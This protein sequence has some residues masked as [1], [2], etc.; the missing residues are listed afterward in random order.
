MRVVITGA[1]GG[2]GRA[3]VRGFSNA[4]FPVRGLVRTPTACRDLEQVCGDIRDPSAA[5]RLP[6]GAD[7]IIHVAGVAHRSICG[8]PELAQLFHD[9]N[10]TGTENVCRA[11]VDAGTRAIMLISSSAVYGRSLRAG[12]VAETAPCLPDSAYGASKVGAEQA[13][14][15][16]CRG[17]STRLRVL[18][19]ATVYGPGTR[20]NITRLVKMAGR[21]VVV[22]VAPGTARKSLI[23]IDDLVR[24]CLVLAAM[25]PRTETL[26][27]AGCRGYAVREI[28]HAIRRCS[29]R[30]VR[31]IWLPRPLVKLIARGNEY[32]ARSR[33]FPCVIDR[34][35]I[36]A[37]TEDAVIDASRLH[38]RLGSAV[39]MTALETG[40]GRMLAEEVR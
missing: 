12:P 1:S 40:I 20:G 5:R 28:L 7:L 25:E 30:R 3:L 22:A 29:S 15:V 21:G 23:F 18:R 2:I 39:S 10:V 36:R 24:V 38:E 19:L 37:L 26:N 34:D 17:S 33:R 31:E 9:V 32:A 35:A 27:V 16:I 13:A 4:G 8:R 11:A 14:E 6:G